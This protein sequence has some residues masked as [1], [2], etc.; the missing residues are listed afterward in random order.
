MAFTVY[1]NPHHVHV[2]TSCTD[3]RDCS[4]EHWEGGRPEPEHPHH[5]E[6]DC[7]TGLVGYTRL[8][9]EEIA[10][11]EAQAVEV[12]KQQAIIDA[13]LKDRQDLVRARAKDDPAFKALAEH[14]GIALEDV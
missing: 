9:A 10:E 5:V 1:F 13:K 14:L 8:T 2:E 11:R 12:A 3:H 7:S 4:D 6:V